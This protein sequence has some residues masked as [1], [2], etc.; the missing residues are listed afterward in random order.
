MSCLA[1]IN[2]IIDGMQRLTLK[3]R[4]QNV[5]K[6][7]PPEIIMAVFEKLGASDLARASMVSRR[8]QGLAQDERFWKKFFYEELVFWGEDEWKNAGRVP[9]DVPTIAYREVYCIVKLFNRTWKTDSDKKMMWLQPREVVEPHAERPVLLTRRKVEEFFCKMSKSTLYLSP[10]S[11]ITDLEDE[12]VSKP[13]WIYLMPDVEER[14]LS[15]LERAKR[16]FGLTVS[17]GEQPEAIEGMTAALLKLLQS[18]KRLYSDV[19]KTFILCK[20]VLAGWG[21]Q[22]ALGNLSEMTGGYSLRMSTAVDQDD[23]VPQHLG[24]ALLLRFYDTAS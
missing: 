1:A 16:L 19:P 11:V 22:V 3:P 7:V 4:P 12:P 20:D 13:C 18:G 5:E 21:C 14:C 24:K 2:D 6:K 15:I 23:Q 8:W 10:T 17:V 9:L